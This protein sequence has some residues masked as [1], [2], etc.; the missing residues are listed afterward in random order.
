MFSFNKNKAKMGLKDVALISR[1]RDVNLGI[2]PNWMEELIFKDRYFVALNKL[3]I[4]RSTKRS[5]TVDSLRG[6][7]NRRR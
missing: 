7:V 1:L 3:S 6:K 2:K 4:K 5:S